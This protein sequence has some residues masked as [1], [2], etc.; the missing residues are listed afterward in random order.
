[1]KI[2]LLS[3]VLEE[4]TFLEVVKGGHPR[5]P[6]AQNFYFRLL[7]ALQTSCD[8]RA[9]TPLS[10]HVQEQEEIRLAFFKPSRLHPWAGANALEKQAE[11]LSW[12]GPDIILYDS[13][14]LQCAKAALRIGKKRGIPAIPILTDDPRNITGTG[15]AYRFL[16]KRLSRNRPAYLGLTDGLNDLFNPKK[17]PFFR[18]L[19]I[20]E[21]YISYPRPVEGSYFYYGGALYEKDGA[22]SLLRAYRRSKTAIPFYFAGHGPMA[23]DIKEAAKTDDRIHFLG[24]LD[25]AQ[26]AAFQ[27]HA[28]LVLNARHYRESLDLVSLPSKDLEYL[29]NASRIA[30]TPSKPLMEEFPEDALWLHEGIDE[31]ESE[32]LSIFDQDGASVPENGA[33]ERIASLIGKEAIG[34]RIKVFLESL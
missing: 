12:G 10:F 2:L 31:L 21:D 22:G 20:G 27:Q 11:C 5:N 18:F 6:A 19:G 9:I 4:K 16:V 7:K 23:K 29:A 33:K 34:K 26:N 30:L 32:L 8:V 1:M 17:R 3:T 13:L 14:N 25:R 15:S 24:Q 28:L